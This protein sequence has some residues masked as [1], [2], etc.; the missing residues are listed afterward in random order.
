VTVTIASPNLQGTRTTVTGDGGGYSFPSLPPGR[1]TVT[2]ELEGLQTVTKTASLAV[3]TGGKVDAALSVTAVAEA[4]TVTA[5]APSV[6]DTS[7]V[8]S[9]FDQPQIDEL[10]INRNPL[11][12]A[13]LAPGV[14]AGVTAAGNS[15]N[16]LSANQMVISGSPGYDNLIMVNGV[17]ITENVRS[18]A[19]NLYIEDAIQETT[20]LTGAISAEFG[21]FTGGVVNSIT[22]SGGNEFSGSL[23]DSFDNPSWTD[24]T[25]FPG[26]A[27]PTDVQ[28]ETYEATIGGFVVRDRLWFFGAG[29]YRDRSDDFSTVLP[30]GS[31]NST[32][33]A[34]TRGDEERRLE[35]KLTAQLSQKHSIVASYLDKDRSLNNTRFTATIYDADSLTTQDTPETL[36]S[37]HYNGILTNS[38][39]V[40]GQYSKRELAFENS[41]S[42]F[43]D[44]VRGTLM[45]NVGVSPN[46]R[47]NSPTF[48]GVCDTETRTNEG[49]L[50]KGS[51]FLSTR[52]L[53]N[54]NFVIGGEDFAEHRYANNHQ[55]GSDFRFRVPGARMINNVVYPTMDNSALARIRWTPIFVGA[56]ENDLNTQSVFLNDKWDL[57]SHWSF[58]LGMRWDKNK[59]VD[60]IGNVASNDDKISPRVTAILDAKG[61]GRH[62]FTASY[63]VY[64]SR[65][66]EGPGT[67]ADSAGSP[68]SIDF[69]YRGPALN[70]L[71]A[72]PTLNSQQVAQA[73]FDWFN[74]QCN[75]QGQCGT[76]NLDLLHP[77]GLRS[78][79]GYDYFFDGSLTSPSVDE[80][81]LGYGV[82]LGRSAYAKIDAI[83]RDWNDFYAARVVQET[84]KITDPLGIG[85]DRAIIYNDNSI[86]R[87]YRGLQMQAQWRPGRVNT[88]MS[89]TYSTLKGNDET[90]TAVS[91]AGPNSPLATF[92]PEIAGY[93]ERLPEGYIDNFDM[94]HKAK[95]WASYDF[96]LGRFGSLAPSILHSYHSGVAY[97]A[98]LVIP[99]PANPA[100][101]DYERSA[102]GTLNYYIDGKRGNYRTDDV[103]STDLSLN[104]RLPLWKTELFLQG[105]MLNVLNNQD[106]EDVNFITKTVTRIAAAPFD[107]RTQDPVAGV[108]YNLSP[109]FG[110]P[111]NFQAYQ[112]PRT[113]RFSVGLRF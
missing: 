88:G 89:Y 105:D 31:V 17:P 15:L 87:K 111:N 14:L 72:A 63:N 19:Q 93:E 102:L 66:I 33:I 20:V 34:Y 29:R 54:H 110:Q 113:Y 41:G 46:A 91:G 61:D 82:M 51:Y 85:H 68:G 45:V 57:N 53:G 79:P 42:K 26:Q 1:Y 43:T 95:L 107:P 35:G 84:G 73:V 28:N 104:Y 30:A 76:A 18:Q 4:I 13:E 22:K 6:F 106:V 60:G 108:N 64:V 100:G 36:L 70:P 47:F 62:R 92:Y 11:A 71:S 86:E 52:N 83:Y 16:A 69:Q 67:A 56:N 3:A 77:S 44:L 80:Y 65:I 74:A 10:P 96:N 75:A 109:T 32:P 37:G 94:R 8:A 21:R 48:C 112:L 101:L 50:L 49:M 99:A 103:N 25:E 38:F 55:S 27:D 7:Q 2:F 81:T 5:S 23:R 12:I 97:S 24:K 98:I 39:L 90:E 9:N 40:E 78:T 59:S 58:N